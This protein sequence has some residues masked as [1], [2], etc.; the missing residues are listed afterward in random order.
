MTEAMDDDFLRGL[1]DWAYLH[2]TE[3]QTWPSTRLADELIAQAR[4]RRPSQSDAKV[5]RA[6][7]PFNGEDF[8]L[9]I[10]D[11]WKQSGAQG[12]GVDGK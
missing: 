4:E 9:D 7:S 1:V 12:V 6:R 5:M 3:G 8:D 2:A 11:E 10:T